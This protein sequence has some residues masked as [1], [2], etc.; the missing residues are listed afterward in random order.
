MAGTEG[1]ISGTVQD[2][3][4]IAV[5]GATIE[6]LSPD[7]KVIIE[8]HS[9]TTGAFNIFPIEFG[10]Y[11]IVVKATGHPFYRDSVHV[12]SGSTSQVTAKLTRVADP[13]E[14][15]VHVQAKRRRKVQDSASTST[16]QISKE[17]IK[18]LPQGDQI[19]LPKLLSSTT[20]GVVMGTF[21]QMFFRGNHANI[22]YQI[23]GVQLPDSPS[24]TFGDAFTP[25]N[26]DH[27]EVIT[28]G[29]PAEYGQRLAA[30][31]NIVSKTGP[32]KMGGSLEANY[33]S[34]NQFSPTGTFGGSTPDGSLH[35]YLSGNF[36]RTDRGLETPQPISVGDVSQGGSDSI[37]N[38]AS[39]HNEFMK[40][41]W[42]ADNNNKLTFMAFNSNNSLQIPN[43]PSGFTP[44]DSIFKAGDSFG[45]TPYLYRPSTTDNSQREQNFFVQTVW[46][47]TFTER[48]FLQIAPYFKYSYLGVKNDPTNDLTGASKIT[49]PPD[50][51][52]NN[53]N[54]VYASFSQSRNTNNFGLKAD[55]TYRPNESHLIKA[56]VQ[57]QASKARGSFTIQT[58][59][60]DGTGVATPTTPTAFGIPNDGYFEGIYVQDDFTIFKSLVLNAGLR[61]D[62]TQFNLGPGVNPTDSALQPRVGLNYLITDTTKLHAFYGKLFQPA[63]VENLRAA[64]NALVSP[65]VVPYDIKS[66]RSDFYEVGVA[67]ELPYNHVVSTTVY[68]KDARNLLDDSQLF[69]TAIAQPINFATGYVYGAEVS[70][71]G[72]F[73]DDLTH[74]INYS[75]SI[76]KGKGL[77]GGLFTGITPAT[78]YQFLD[79][80][81]THTLNAGATYRKHHYWLT[82]QGL[83]GSGLRT[84]LNNSLALPGHLTFDATVGYEFHGGEWWSSGL[85][86]SLDVLNMGDNRHPVSVAN[87]FN[88]SHYAAG[89]Q[90]YVHLVKEF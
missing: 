20:P 15:V 42:I 67:Q 56:G 55:Y 49:L 6:I 2:E 70:L 77:T 58:A 62:A 83:F 1:T 33:G 86:V 27:M 46:K 51:G 65:T 19:K 25:R 37:H 47:H 29:I 74:Y 18:D 61:F 16:S 23:D 87:G 17:D 38:N 63:P 13:K 85:K 57:V 84:G 59:Q 78:D 64:F 71:R 7:E 53:V 80:S 52:G 68:Y 75:Y 35:Y 26:I 88:G 31:V 39:G 45:N 21:G 5:S 12:S 50:S 89:R 69:N 36:N 10:D 48:S 24:G 8:T 79:H 90:F 41:D 73:I 44:K 22:Q 82:V 60:N 32:E 66:E 14:M 4:E 28:G 76:G 3:Q 72:Q 11:T 34:Y 81:Q 43:F 30:V 40:M 54:P 9:S